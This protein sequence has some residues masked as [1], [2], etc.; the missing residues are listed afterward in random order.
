[1][2]TSFKK[3]RT[4]F[5]SPGD[6]CGSV[7]LFSLLF[8]L[9]SCVHVIAFGRFGHRLDHWIAQIAFTLYTFE[10]RCSP[11]LVVCT[12]FLSPLYILLIQVFCLLS[13]PLPSPVAQDLS[14]IPIR[15]YVH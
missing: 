11:G 13:N 5:L 2:R 3:R 12:S 1:M 15:F 14:P 10:A 8:C 4:I 6:S 9:L 7:L